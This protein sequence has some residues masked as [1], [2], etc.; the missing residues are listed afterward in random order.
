MAMKGFSL[1]IKPLEILSDEQ[2]EKI[3]QGTLEVLEETGI[4]I[5]HDRALK[6]FVENGCKVN[7]KD[8]RVRIP[9]Y[10]VEEC[11]NKAPNSYIVKARHPKNNLRIGGNTL[12]FANFPGMRTVDLNTWEYRPATKKENADAIKILDGLDNIH[13]LLCYTPYFEVEGIPPVMA[14]PESVAAK[15][16]NSTKVQL[17]GYAHDCEIFTIKMAQ[18]AGTEIFGQCAASPPLTYQKDAI[19]SAFRFV[20]AG[21]PLH[22]GTGDVFGATSP[23]TIAGSII[24]NNAEIIAIVVLGQLIKPGTRIIAVDFVFPQNMRTGEPA[25]GA[26]GIGLHQVIFNQIWRRKYKIP[27]NSASIGLSSSKKADFQCG[28][29]KAINTLLSA[30]SGAS[31]IQLHGG[32]YGEITYH[33]VQ[34]ILDDDIAGMVGRFVEGVEVTDETL[35]TDLIKEVGPIP[36]YYLNKEHTRRWWKKEQFLPKVADRLTYREWL[37]RGKKDALG[38][39]KERM[40]EIFTTHEPLRLSKD[41]DREIENILEETRKYYIEKGKM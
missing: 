2:I 25:F 28:Y 23:A 11:L 35:A 36:G 12:Y 24:T 18:V 19:E 32:I 13:K 40:E 29:E 10:L 5:E 16:R 26:I 37:K 3:H 41:Q 30:L 6:L 39:A 38:Y 27:T 1:K 8:K 21:L 34:S 33:P 9:G 7:F 17:T 31:I 15:M 14:I 22:V 20:E 4:R